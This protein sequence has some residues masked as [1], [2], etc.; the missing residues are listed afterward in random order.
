MTI[1]IRPRP[2]RMRALAALLAPL[3]VL[4]LL[5]IAAPAAADDGVTDPA[6]APADPGVAS[7][8]FASSEPLPSLA[9]WK[10]VVPQGAQRDPS[11]G[12]NHGEVIGI[13]D[14]GEIFGRTGIRSDDWNSGRATRWNADGTIADVWGEGSAPTALNN[15]GVM[16]GATYDGSDQPHAVMWRDGVQIALPD[17]GASRSEALDVSDSGVVSGSVTHGGLTVAVVW[18]LATGT[19]ELHYVPLPET[20]SSA[21]AL[22]V[23]DANLVLVSTDYTLTTEGVVSPGAWLWW[24]GDEQTMPTPIPGA[25]QA[26]D[27][28]DANYAVVNLHTGA[29]NNRSALFHLG[30]AAPRRILGVSPTLDSAAVDIN[31]S[32]DVAGIMFECT[33]CGG[34]EPVVWEREMGDGY[35]VPHRLKSLLAAVPGYEDPARHGVSAAL[36]INDRRSVVVLLGTSWDPRYRDYLVMV[37]D[38][39]PAQ[40]D[41]ARLESVDYPSGDWQ[42][43]PSRGVVQGTASRVAFEVHNPDSRGD[44]IVSVELRDA[45]TGQRMP[46]GYWF[47]SLHPFAEAEGAIEFDTSGLAFDENGVARPPMNLELVVKGDGEEVERIPIELPVSPDPVVLVHGFNSSA[48]AWAEYDSY[49][50]SVHPG[51]L[52]FAVGDGAGP[53]VMNTGSLAA[54]D[55]PAYTLAQNAAIEAEYIEWIRDRTNAPHIDIVAHSMG[56][57]ISRQYINDWMPMADDGT[58][59]VSQLIM[60]GTP[61]AGSPCA[62]VMNLA[63]M[64]DLRRD[65]LADFNRRIINRKGVEMSI[66]VGSIVP[67]TCQ[68]EE[69]GD[70]V[71]P[72]SSTMA[73]SWDDS[74]RT[75][76]LHTSMTNRRIF[77]F[78][79]WPEL[80]GGGPRGLREDP[81][82]GMRLLP[83]DP[84]A[85]ADAAASAELPPLLLS[86]AETV[87]AGDTLEV[88]FDADDSSRLGVAAVADTGIR[89]ELVDP[90]GDVADSGEGGEP[91]LSLSSP[92]QPAAGTWRLRVHN[93]S[94]T[95]LPVGLAVYLNN[96]ATT[97]TASIALDDYGVARVTADVA[98]GGVRLAG[99]AVSARF[100]SGGGTVRQLTL[101][102]QP[103]GTYAGAS[104]SLPEGQYR[105]AVSA[106]SGD[107]QR[108]TLLDLAVGPSRMDTIKP[109]I[110]LEYPSAGASGWHRDR[111]DGIIRA[112]DTGSGVGYVSYEL[113]GA[114]EASGETPESSLA[115]AVTGE[116]ESELWP[117]AR[118]YAGNFRRF[119]TPFTFLVDATA[120]TVTIEGV[121]GATVEQGAELVA[122]YVCADAHSGVASCAGDVS[123]GATLPTDVPG[124]HTFTVQATDAVG[125]ETVQTATYTVAGA[126]PDDTT[127]PVATASLPATGPHGWYGG[128]VT[129]ALSA[130]DVGSGV[131]T[132]SWRVGDA[133]THTV[134]GDRTEVPVTAAGETAVIYWATDAVGNETAHAVAVV[135]IDVDGP[136]VDV[137]SP[138]E[139]QRLS[140]GE[141]VVLDY[142]AT[143]EESGVVSAAATVT[144]P[145]AELAK[146]PVERGDAVPSQAPGEY[147]ITVTAVD[148]VGHETRSE[149]R[150]TVVAAAPDTTPPTAAATVPSGW[151]AGPATVRLTASDEA[152]GVAAI[153]WRLTGATQATGSAAGA[154]AEF[155]VTADGATE[156][157]YWAVDGAGNTGVARQ[158]RVRVDATPPEVS[159]EGLVDGGT[160]HAA[161]VGDAAYSCA[162]GVS[163]VMSCVGSTAIG[164]PL[165]SE[166]GGHALVVEAVD[167]AGN[168]ASIT[169]HYTV[170]AEPAAELP[171]GAGTP[172]DSAA[173]PQDL[174]RTG[175]GT[176]TVAAWL[177]VALLL[178]GTALVFTHRRRSRRGARWGGSED[179]ASAVLE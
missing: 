80:V 49:L 171:G 103:D 9:E 91:M 147:V 102:V 97:V 85:D 52:S 139:G 46:D 117:F 8:D 17:D 163:G 144:G 64:R 109:T 138:A 42:P 150:Y 132:V 107:M 56:G 104:Q 93:S 44:H 154:V 145:D 25:V 95:S 69:D 84:Q 15:S 121:D 167:E 48:A 23:N 75:N 161:D 10:V 11:D 151:S 38:E 110:Q 113:H 50:R 115:F 166:V 60:L 45:D 86:R 100:A 136:V 178:F 77:D 20:A 101:H 6:P 96:A 140:V 122:H 99:A 62:D 172:G 68:S 146:M 36:D 162:D 153:G 137:G 142:Q 89:V 16:V 158:A 5:S 13:N 79:V 143:D 105:V 88:P 155:T 92:E 169:V 119:D 61:N 18:Y 141:R 106:A 130:T 156:I 157:E 114:T 57:L 19:P 123:D 53:G 98:R 63:G 126:V 66:L 32:N 35:P 33:F 30:D 70:L 149:R 40:L 41:D 168:R 128:P 159:V 14:E 175:G 31:S 76:I 179:P 65:V 37:P 112:A 3:L 47:E 26:I 94:D 54:P 134:R 174:A 12:F 108:V 160:Y 164:Q 74:A 177:A 127:A 29:A 90:S 21:R 27:L 170:V 173:G 129:L 39:P 7:V 4:G 111:V 87:E 152:S 165:P 67:F 22:R 51:W 133:E 2:P 120:P 28:N 24:V 135:R 71:V 34:A 73:S 59:F 176:P 131:A 118:D 58:P 78:F 1:R 55:T 83:Y 72:E 116:G 148:A 124:P 125:H 43:M 82:S 81:A